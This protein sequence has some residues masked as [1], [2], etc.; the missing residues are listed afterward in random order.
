VIITGVVLIL[1][2]ALLNVPIL[3]TIGIILVIAGVVLWILGAMG[4]TIGPR[5]YYW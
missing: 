4:R 3:Y 2:A 1:L 5:R